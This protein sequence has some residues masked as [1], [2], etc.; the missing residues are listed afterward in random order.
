[1]EISELKGLLKTKL[2]HISEF[3]FDQEP[4]K[5]RKKKIQDFGFDEGD[6]A[7]LDILGLENKKKERKF[8]GH[9]T[10][11][12]FEFV[13]KK[14]GI[15]S[16]LEKMGFRNLKLFLNTDDQYTHKAALYFERKSPENLL[17]EMVCK[18]SYLKLNTPDY[19]TLNGKT[20]RVLSLEWIRLQ[21][22]KAEFS[23]DLPKLPGQDYPGLGMGY[24]IF[25]LIVNMARRI[26]CEAILNIPE[27]YSELEVLA[28]VFFY[29]SP[30]IPQS[31][32]V[33]S[34]D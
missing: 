6:L 5:R 27:Y 21:N 34:P 16:R 10:P 15:Y 24:E 17:G 18:I 8:L 23:P 28:K 26:E 29:P 13:L 32:R 4:R 33:C 1:M 2:N 12:N 30:D 3:I 22:P 20:I 11:K 14:K 19:K 31:G 9:F 7:D 25:R